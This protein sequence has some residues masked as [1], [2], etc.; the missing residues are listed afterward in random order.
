MQLPTVVIQLEQFT[1]S[2]PIYNGRIIKVKVDRV[3]TGKGKEATR[4]IV[5]HR[6]AAAIVPLLNDDQVILVTQ[7]RYAIASNLL[8]VPA[9]TLEPG[10]PPDLCARRELEEE[11]GYKCNELT[12]IMELYVTPGYGTEKIHIF[13]ARGLVRT[14]MKNEE[15]EDIN[16][17]T[18]PIEKA[19]EKV[20]RG[21]ITDAKS[22]CALYRTAELLHS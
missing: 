20:R 16:V 15:D 4:E 18:M 5:E 12:K 13:L 6:G 8:E 10:E 22:I 21:E 7:Y 14:T 19:M 17:Q 1:S 11:T 9:G 3:V 2:T